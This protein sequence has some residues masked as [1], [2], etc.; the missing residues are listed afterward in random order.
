MAEFERHWKISPTNFI[1]TSG[2]KAISQEVGVVVFAGD[3]IT[4]S[5]K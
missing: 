4:T 1:D 3:F 2:M 5:P